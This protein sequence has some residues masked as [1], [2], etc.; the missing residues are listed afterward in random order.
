MG[1]GIGG[2]IYPGSAAAGGSVALSLNTEVLSPGVNGQTVFT[3]STAYLAGGYVLLI[4][5][6]LA[7]DDTSPYF[8]I[9]GTTLT[10]LDATFVLDTSDCLVII[11]QVP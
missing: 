8:T 3:L 6:N 5:N 9:A 1:V 11:Y 4:L 2:G 10:W 7:Y